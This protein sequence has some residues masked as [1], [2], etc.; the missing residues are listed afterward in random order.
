[1]YEDLW[2]HEEVCMDLWRACECM[3][4]CGD[5]RRACRDVDS[6]GAWGRACGNVERACGDMGAFLGTCGMLTWEE[7]RGDL[8]RACVYVGRA[9][10]DLERA[11]WDVGKNFGDMEKASV[12]TTCV[13]MRGELV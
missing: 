12:G 8:R 11:W 2:G 13:G 5:L 1:M 6:L 4:V 7:L 3:K 9:C 10:G